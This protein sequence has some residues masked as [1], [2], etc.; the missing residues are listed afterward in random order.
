MKIIDFQVENQWFCA[1]MCVIL[2]EMIEKTHKNVTAL[3]TLMRET[4][5]ELEKDIQ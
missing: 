3:C 4:W 1:K 2:V 5:K